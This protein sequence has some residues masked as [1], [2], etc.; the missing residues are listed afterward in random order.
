MVSYWV[1]LERWKSEPFSYKS[2][3]KILC[4]CLARRFCFLKREV[5]D[6]FLSCQLRAVYIESEKNIATHKTWRRKTGNTTWSVQIGFLY[7]YLAFYN[8]KK[9]RRNLFNPLSAR[10]AIYRL[11]KYL[12]FLRSWTPT[13]GPRSA[14]THEPW[15]TG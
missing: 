2:I 9:I 8:L 7:E 13:R 14:A 5:R 12:S 1:I 11:W 10:W 6:L 3:Y 15:I 4:V